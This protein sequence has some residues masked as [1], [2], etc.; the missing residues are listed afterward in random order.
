MGQRMRKQRFTMQKQAKITPN[1]MVSIKLV[2]M[3]LS[4][5]PNGEQIINFN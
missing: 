4:S 5:P 3:L 2:S 1:K